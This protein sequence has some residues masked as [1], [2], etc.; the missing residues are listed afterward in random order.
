MNYTILRYAIWLFALIFAIGFGLKYKDM[1]ST[2][3]KIHNV[4]GET[5]KALDLGG[6]FTL[7]NQNGQTVKSEDTNGKIRIV[8]FGYTYCPDLCPLALMNITEALNDLKNDRDSVATYFITVDP[9]R[10]TITKLKE[11]SENF[12]PNIQM[13]YGSEDELKPI[14]KSYKV[15]AQRVD[16]KKFGDY[17][18][19]HSTF[20]YIL[21]KEG[22]VVDILPHTTSGKKIKEA[23]LTQIF[24]KNHSS[25]SSEKMTPTNP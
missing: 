7:K 13:L 1:F 2:T 17:L 12:H 24:Y 18:I 3:A 16:D 11:Y 25:L 5:V 14:K 19:D 22:K 21:N 10:D 4:E 6:P 9:E 8:Y 15:I 23:V 20:I